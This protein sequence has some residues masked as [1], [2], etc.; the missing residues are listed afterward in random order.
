M[1]MQNSQQFLVASKT[2]NKLLTKPT[3]DELTELY[4]LYKQATCGDNT[5]SKPFMIDFK[6]CVK[7]D[8]WTKYKGLDVYTSEIKYITLV[9][10]LIKKYK[11]GI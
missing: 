10:T 2:V 7:W 8:A 1:L 4:G 5:Q 6:G 11:L 3:D 9:N